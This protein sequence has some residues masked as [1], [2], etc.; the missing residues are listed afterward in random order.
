VPYNIEGSK[1]IWNKIS[2]CSD[3]QR[4]AG[5]YFLVFFSVAA[6]FNNAKIYLLNDAALHPRRPDSASLL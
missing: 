3:H 2:K 6:A 1:N 4:N 5:Q